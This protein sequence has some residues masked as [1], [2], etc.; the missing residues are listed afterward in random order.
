MRIKILLT[1]I[2]IFTAC[3]N[4]A[5][6]KTDNDSRQKSSS[7]I[8]PRP[9]FVQNKSRADLL[10]P[11]P[12]QTISIPQ[13]F[14][15][16]APNASYVSVLIF[17]TNVGVTAEA[18]QS[19]SL[20]GKCVAGV[21]SLAGHAMTGSTARLDTTASALTSFYKCYAANPNEPLSTTE[22]LSSD[23]LSSGTYYWLVLGYNENRILTHASGLE[24]FTK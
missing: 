20:A 23:D 17:N 9:L 16:S 10:S 7:T 13:T 4:N 18:F 6:E 3:I 19:G 8:Q 1:S 14:Y 5:E 21:S 24:R 15:F 11:R 22:K 12:L 2:F